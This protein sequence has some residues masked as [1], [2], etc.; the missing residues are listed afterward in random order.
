MQILTHIW[1]WSYV[2]T[3][4]FQTSLSLGRSF[5]DHYFL[6]NHTLVLLFTIILLLIFSL[7]LFPLMTFFV[8][9]VVYAFSFS[10]LI[11]VLSYSLTPPPWFLV[12]NSSHK[13]YRCMPLVMGHVYISRHA[14]FFENIFPFAN[15]SK[16]SLCNKVHLLSPTESLTTHPWPLYT[17]HPLLIFH[18]HT[19]CQLLFHHLLT[20][21]PFCTHQL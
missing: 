13:G 11:I 3:S 1:Y 6:I 21:I 7:I 10:I 16:S 20:H 9:L 19:L 17:V 18:H 14:Q 4:C 2:I 15:S 8:P 5:P 12:C